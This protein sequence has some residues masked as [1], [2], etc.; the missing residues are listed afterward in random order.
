MADKMAASME[1]HWAF[2]SANSKAASMGGQT[3]VKSEF[4]KVA[5]MVLQMAV[6]L[7]ALTGLQEAASKAE[8]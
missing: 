1:Y 5:T 2:L 3:A 7:A 8:S 6:E 4:G